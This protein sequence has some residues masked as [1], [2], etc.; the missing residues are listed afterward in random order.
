VL[1]ETEVVPFP[2]IKETGSDV[3]K[4]VVVP[5]WKA[6]ALERAS[7]VPDKVVPFKVTLP[8]GLLTGAA[9]R[10]TASEYKREVT[11]SSDITLN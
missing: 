5:I 8:T 11:L 1:V 3:P 4:A 9:K 6:A 7:I 2:L 10:F